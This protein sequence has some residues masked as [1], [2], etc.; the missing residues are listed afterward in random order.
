MGAVVGRQPR[1]A[2]GGVM[3]EVVHYLVTCEVHGIVMTFEEE[4]AAETSLTVHQMAWGCQ[5]ATM[6]QVTLQTKE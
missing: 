5:V 1:R 4:E 6:H 3:S 2:E